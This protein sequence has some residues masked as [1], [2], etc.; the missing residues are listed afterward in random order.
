M[1]PVPPWDTG[2]SSGRNALRSFVFLVFLVCLTIHLSFAT[3][4]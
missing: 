4:L 1:V 2:V 3:H